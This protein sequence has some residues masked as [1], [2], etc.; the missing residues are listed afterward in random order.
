[1]RSAFD[2]V[3]MFTCGEF[4]GDYGNKWRY[5]ISKKLELW[6]LARNKVENK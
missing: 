2:L 1:M 4:C 6:R 5:S 3:I